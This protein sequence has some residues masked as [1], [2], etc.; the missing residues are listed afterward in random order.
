MTPKREKWIQNSTVGE[1]VR[2]IWDFTKI[3]TIQFMIN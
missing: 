2:S 1:W 3:L